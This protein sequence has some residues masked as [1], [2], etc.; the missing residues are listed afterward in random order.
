MNTGAF[1][2][3]VVVDRSQVVPV[4]EDVAPDAAS[5]LAC[6]VITGV[7]AVVNSAP[8]APARTSW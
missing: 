5:L 3:R 7:G 8:S 2:E 4:P 1:A 6:G